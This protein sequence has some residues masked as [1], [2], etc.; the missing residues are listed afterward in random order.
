MSCANSCNSWNKAAGVFFPFADRY[1]SSSHLRLSDS[2]RQQVTQQVKPQVKQPAGVIWS[3]LIGLLG[4]YLSA[5]KASS[6]VDLL[7][8]SG[9]MC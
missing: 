7:V 3:Y 4:Y 1:T 5:S 8:S 9:A 6:K 2:I